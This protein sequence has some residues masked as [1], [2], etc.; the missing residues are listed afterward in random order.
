MLKVA[1]L[2]E[3]T[4]EQCA[5]FLRIADSANALDAS[6]V[7]PEAYPVVERILKD[8]GREIKSVMGD[9]SFLRSI[10][11]ENYT[12]E[13]FGVPTIRDILKE[14]EK[15]GRDPRPEFKAATFAD[16]IE[17][18]KDLKVGMILE[19]VVSNVAAFGAFVDI[20]VHQDGLIHISALADK[21]VKDPREVVKAG[22]VIK[23]R[24]LEVDI[25]RKRIALTR[26]L[27]DPIEGGSESATRKAEPRA[28]SPTKPSSPAKP[29]ANSSQ[30]QPNSALAAAFA[31]AKQS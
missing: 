25:Q 20:G 9:S 22:D 24:V 28:T 2:G 23:V 3:K 29:R 17:E 4:F 10:K 21:F 7:H 19:G 26:R 14:L 11:P 27:S 1:R 13:K 8:C 5:G 15:P 30:P 16:G 31:K 18:L 12:D 6:S